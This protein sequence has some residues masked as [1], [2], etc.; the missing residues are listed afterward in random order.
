M[1]TGPECFCSGVIWVY[2]SHCYWEKSHYWPTIHTS[3]ITTASH[4]IKLRSSWRT[5]SPVAIDRPRYIVKE[6]S[7]KNITGNSS[8]LFNLTALE[9]SGV[10]FRGAFCR[11]KAFAQH[12][13]FNSLHRH[14]ETIYTAKKLMTSL[15]YAPI[16]TF[17]RKVWLVWEAL[18]LRNPMTSLSCGI[19]TF[20]R[21]MTSPL[22]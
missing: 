12:G 1:W 13:Y 15:P 3:H 9:D 5:G 18:L 10:E 19:Q 14:Q 20:Q 7:S 22:C 4:S 17:A 2:S 16:P 8:Q 6:S 21:N 11:C